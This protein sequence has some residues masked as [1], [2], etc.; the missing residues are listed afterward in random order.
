MEDFK[1]I[2]E[3]YK[4]MKSRYTCPQCGHKHRFT[5]FIDKGTGQYLSDSVGRCD[6]ENECTYIYTPSSF[7]SDNPSLRNTVTQWDSRPLVTSVTKNK[8][9]TPVTDC[10]SQP[11]QYLPFEI[12]ERSVK[13]CSKSSLFPFLDK[14]FTGEIAEQLCE[15]YCIGSNKDGNTVFWQ[16]DV[17]GR[18]HQAKV[19]N[20]NSENGKRNKD[21]TIFFAGKKILKDDNAHLQQCFFGEN[22]LSDIEGISKPV[23]IVE[24]EKTAVIAS[25]YYPE[26]IWLATGGKHGCKW[27]ESKV[28]NVLH[29]R[30]IILFPDLGALEAWKAKGL[31]LAA[32]AGC[33]VAVSDLLERLANDEDKK[34]GLDLADFLLR[35]KDATEFALTDH[36]YP[37]MWDINKSQPL[38]KTS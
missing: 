24:S 18:I 5:R 16:V 13:Q 21:K 4:G 37:V 19:I 26:F 22:L 28:C 11:L 25:V 35:K 9:V 14:L 6:R 8:N 34:Q 1:Y 30:R 23:A 17:T 3:P 29:K 36:G 15:D 33:K 32:V 27:T 20:Y 7:F 31:L 10:Y 12:M 38:N 2:L